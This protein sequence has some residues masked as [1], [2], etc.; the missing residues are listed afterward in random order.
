VSLRTASSTA[1]SVTVNHSNGQT[2]TVTEIEVATTGGGDYRMHTRFARF[3]NVPEMP[4]LWHVF[5]DVKTAEDLQLPAPE[6][7]ERR[8]G[9]RAAETVLIDPSPELQS[10]VQ[11]LAR[12]ADAVR[13]RKVTP[14]EDN[15]LKVTTDGRKAALDTR[16]VTVR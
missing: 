4:R 10:Y 12:R 2:Q 9:Q 11:A 14:E 8:D 16:L 1:A 15:M 13:S 6:L 5:A 3:P 7:A